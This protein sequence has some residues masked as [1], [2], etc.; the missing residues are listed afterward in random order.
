MEPLRIHSDNS[1]S[2]IDDDD[3]DDDGLDEAAG[4][5]TV[6][7]LLHV[8]LILRSGSESSCGERSSTADGKATTERRR[9]C[10][11]WFLRHFKG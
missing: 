8:K 3:D 5:L 1:E 7:N 6:V 11:L 4:F 10:S 2:D 9:E